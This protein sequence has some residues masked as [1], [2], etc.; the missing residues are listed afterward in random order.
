MEELWMQDC[1]GEGRYGYGYDPPVNTQRG[2][3]P[4]LPS[5]C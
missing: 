4:A 5:L 1:G 3:V 2:Q